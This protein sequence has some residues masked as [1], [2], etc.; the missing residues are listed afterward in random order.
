M[1]IS[2]FQNKILILSV[3][4]LSHEIFCILCMRTEDFKALK[5]H[6]VAFWVMILCSVS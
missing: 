1:L 6:T 4:L 2:S 3:L 5:T